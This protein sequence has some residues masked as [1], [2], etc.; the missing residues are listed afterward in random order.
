MLVALM[1]QSLINVAATANG[2]AP[3][4]VHAALQVGAAPM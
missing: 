1:L 2:K 4:L 3:P